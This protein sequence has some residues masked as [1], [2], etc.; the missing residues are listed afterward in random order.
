MGLDK[1]C[2]EYPVLFWEVEIGC[3]EASKTSGLAVLQ[4]SQS[5]GTFCCAECGLD[6][7]RETMA[8]NIVVEDLRMSNYSAKTP[9]QET[10]SSMETFALLEFEIL[11]Y[12]AMMAFTT[13]A[14][15]ELA[16]IGIAAGFRNFVSVI[17]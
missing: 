16:R 6:A 8:Q 1:L 4:T 5:L 17:A 7:S 11:E 13:T 3:R 12:V 9:F 15:T 14:A 10:P 2:L